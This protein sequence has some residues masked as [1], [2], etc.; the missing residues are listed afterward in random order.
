MALIRGSQAIHGVAVGVR[1]AGEDA[2]RRY[3]THQKAQ[4]EVRSA[5]ESEVAVVR[6]AAEGYSADLCSSG[7]ERMRISVG[8]YR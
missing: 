3:A 7:T 8:L 2:M 4:C 5:E 1:S 6:R